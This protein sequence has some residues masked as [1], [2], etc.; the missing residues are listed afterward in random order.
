MERSS[1]ELSALSPYPSPEERDQ[2][3]HSIARRAGA[4]V[5]EYGR[6]REGRPLLAVRVPSRSKQPEHVLCSANIHGIEWIA[7]RVAIGLLQALIDG[8]PELRDRAEV[9]IIPSLNPDG[10]AKTY[11]LG[12]VG[13]VR[14]MRTNAEG[15]DLN[16]NFPMPFG[17]K[18]SWLNI[19]G[20]SKK[21]ST[22]YRGTHPFSEPETRHLDE[23]FQRVPFRASVNL[24]SFMGTMLPPCLRE[25]A[26]REG[27]KKTCAAFRRAQRQ[28]KYRR[29]ASAWFDQFTGEQEDHQHHV[30]KTW[31]ITAEVF[32]IPASYRQHLFAP[33]AFWRFNPHDY[34]YWVKNDVPGIVA[35]FLAALDLPRA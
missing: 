4:E 34:E 26:H 33:S 25:R 11:E 17:A 5:I 10:Y 9:W 6:S 23:L 20:S 24:H 19:A 12:G 27:Y 29:I 35:Y 7:G 15:V 32:P 18:P 8:E 13:P 21:G 1:R 16:R 22:F 2:E 14:V 3:V 28:I 31:A 30:Y